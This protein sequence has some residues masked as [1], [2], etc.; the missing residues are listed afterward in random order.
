[1]QK[2]ELFKFFNTF[3]KLSQTSFELFWSLTKVE[4]LGSGDMFL[5]PESN[6][7]KIGIVLSGALKSYFLTYE[8]NHHI[9]AF[10]SK[11]DISAAFSSVQLD[12]RPNLFVEALADS[13]LLTFNYTNFQKICESNNELKDLAFKMLEIEFIKNEK[14]EYYF[15]TKSIDENFK[16]INQELNAKKL[17]VMQKDIANYLGITDIAY[18]RIKKRLV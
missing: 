12:Y 4:T 14:K 2:E 18:S 11:F 9:R 5:S 16:I 6:K 10:L 15:A 8:G 3:C 1:M 17:K 7:D 13:T